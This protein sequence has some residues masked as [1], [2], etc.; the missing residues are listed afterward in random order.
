[1]IP[2]FEHDKL[3]S[4]GPLQALNEIGAIEVKIP[5]DFVSPIIYTDF[6]RVLTVLRRSVEAKALFPFFEVD[7]P[8]FTRARRDCLRIGDTKNIENFQKLIAGSSERETL[9]DY[10]HHFWEVDRKSEKLFQG[11][12]IDV[13]M[14]MLGIF[15][16]DAREVGRTLLSEHPDD[17]YSLSFKATNPGLE[18]KLN[19]ETWIESSTDET[20]AVI[21]GP[22]VL[23]R[24]VS[25]VKAE[26]I[27]LLY[28]GTL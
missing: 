27:S 2:V 19:N 9:E 28:A 26:R 25:K 14:S 21:V 18:I 11:L 12:G 23:H 10:F 15:R 7:L 13:S 8:N 20:R 22:G 6:S 17:S 1:M 3:Y 24:V 5:R 16:Y 4:E